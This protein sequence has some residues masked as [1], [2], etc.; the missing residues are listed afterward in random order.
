[1][2]TDHSWVLQSFEHG[3]F[4]LGC[5][6]LHWICQSVFLI[7][8]DSIPGLGLAVHAD[9]YLSVRTLTYNFPDLIVLE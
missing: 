4:S 1:M 8:L 2:Q 9:F 3:Y 5:F 6:P 7:D